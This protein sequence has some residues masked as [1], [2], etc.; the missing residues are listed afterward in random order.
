MRLDIEIQP[1][2][3]ER[4][5]PMQAG[6]EFAATVLYKKQGDEGQESH[7]STSKIID[8][9]LDRLASKER[10]SSL[11]ARNGEARKKR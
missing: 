1:Q 8:I 3:F 4:E 2:P 7:L 5:R 10:S 11:A 6:T 9:A